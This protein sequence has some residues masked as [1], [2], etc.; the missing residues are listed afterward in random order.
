MALL[1]IAIGACVGVI[2]GIII[3]HFT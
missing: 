3:Y 1:V 2:I